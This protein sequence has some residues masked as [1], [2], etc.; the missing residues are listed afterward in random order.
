MPSVSPVQR[1]YCLDGEGEMRLKRA[2]GETYLRLLEITNPVVP[3]WRDHDEGKILFLLTCILPRD[4]FV[5]ELG[6]FMGRTMRYLVGGT[7]ISRSKVLGV[8]TFNGVMPGEKVE[9][10]MWKWWE[11]IC[12]SDSEGV[13]WLNIQTLFNHDHTLFPHVSLFRGTTELAVKSQ[14]PGSVDMVVVDADHTRAWSDFELWEPTLKPWGMV[15]FDD[16]HNP[17]YGVNSPAN[18]VVWLQRKGW[19]AY[20]AVGKIVALTRDPEWWDIR[21]EAF[22]DH[23]GGTGPGHEGAGQDPVPGGDESLRG[24]G[25]PGGGGLHADHVHAGPAGPEE[26]GR[27]E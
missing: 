25:V 23:H 24:G 15:V 3:G 2:F 11:S 27:G 6:V 5:V 10:D 13:A 21:R 4:S 22:V 16:V 1:I 9:I 14:A 7:L 18:A 17:A 19:K 8:D 12:R 20:A 26:D